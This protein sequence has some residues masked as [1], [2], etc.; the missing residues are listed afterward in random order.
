LDIVILLDVSAS[1]GRYV[2]RIA[3]ASQ[4]ALKVL[5]TGDRMGIMVFDRSTRLRLPFS[6]SRQELQRGL[7]RLLAEER[8]NGGTDITRAMLDA[9][10]YI[11]REGRADARRA[12]VILTDDQTEFDRDEAGVSLALV[13]ADAVMCA[14]IA[15]GYVQTQTA[16][17]AQIARNSAGEAIP[18]DQA[19]AL[20]ET[21][22]RIRQ[23]YTLYFTLPEGAR[24]GQPRNIEVD[25]ADATRLHFPDAKVRYRRVYMIPNGSAEAAR[26]EPGHRGDSVSAPSN[27][28]DD[29]GNLEPSLPSHAARGRN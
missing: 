28:D 11:R 3:D 27:T 23:R 22:L 14:L 21:L 20:E 2:R 15:P 17:T 19:S 13:K 4:E 25:L 7:N 29:A 10:S 26:T 1:M 8:F 6:D 12:I 9:A 16:G 5:D 24:P 18:V